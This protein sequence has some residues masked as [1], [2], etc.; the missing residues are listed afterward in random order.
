MHTIFLSGFSHACLSHF[1]SNMA[2]LIAIAPKIAKG[3]GKRGFSYFYAAAIY[4][5]SHFDQSFCR[6]KP[7][8]KEVRFMSWTFPLPSLPS[9][10][11]LGASGAISTLLTYYCLKNPKSSFDLAGIM[12]LGGEK[13]EIPIWVLSVLCYL[14]DLFPSKSSIN[15]G[16]GLG[17]NLF[18]LIAYSVEFLWSKWL[19]RKVGK[20]PKPKDTKPEDRSSLSASSERKS[21]L[22]GASARSRQW[23]NGVAGVCKSFA[24]TWQKDGK[25]VGGNSP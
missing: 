13:L 12:D 17:G 18:G 7:Q 8:P 5:S 3:H 16:H 9:P 1:V 14:S 11:S 15:F 21:S 19:K 25:N 4:A 10:V 22:H 24:T 20:Q 23:A 6:P 2:L